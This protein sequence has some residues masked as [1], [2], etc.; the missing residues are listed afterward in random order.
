MPRGRLKRI[1]AIV[2]LSL[3][4]LAV[5]FVVSFIVAANRMLDRKLNGNAIDW[6]AE[7]IIEHIDTDGGNWPTGWEDLRDDYDSLTISINKPWFFDDFATLVEIDWNAETPAVQSVT[8]PVRVVWLKDGSAD[9][10]TG[11][12]PNQ[13]I[14]QYLNKKVFP[15]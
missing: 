11:R 7:L 10:N 15:P 2:L 4:L 1:L 14:W 13:L 8:E 12:E 9:H 5:R 6:T 3:L